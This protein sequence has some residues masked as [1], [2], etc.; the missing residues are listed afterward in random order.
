M[1]LNG[2]SSYSISNLL[3]N[4][5]DMCSQRKLTFRFL[6]FMTG[7]YVIGSWWIKTDN[8]ILVFGSCLLKKT[9]LHSSERYFWKF[10]PH[11]IQPTYDPSSKFELSFECIQFCWNWINKIFTNFIWISF[12]DFK[13]KLAIVISYTSSSKRDETGSKHM[14]PLY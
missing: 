5:P 3:Q 14:S 11:Q 13:F 8:A 1:I 10:I 7:Y 2:L 6:V 4:K 12:L 9:I